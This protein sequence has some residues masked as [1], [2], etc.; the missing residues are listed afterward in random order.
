MNKNRDK[1]WHIARFLSLIILILS[2]ILSLFKQDL[3][4]IIILII[5]LLL[6]F[7]TND[8]K[9]LLSLIIKVST[10]IISILFFKFI[11]NLF[12]SKIIEFSFLNEISKLINQILNIA[13]SIL[14][15]SIFFKL[16]PIN[17]LS[18][19]ENLNNF[20]SKLKLNELKGKKIESIK[21]NSISSFFAYIISESYKIYYQEENNIKNN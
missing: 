6:Y 21:I 3:I 14:F 4:K 13:N 2:F 11:S 5:Y 10:L 20:I 19:F 1:I 12:Y 15:S 7:I 18:Q 17:S 9:K 8:I 16:I